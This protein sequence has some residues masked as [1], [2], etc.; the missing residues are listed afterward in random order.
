MR[1]ESEEED[2]T[3][4][5]QAAPDKK[6]VDAIKLVCWGGIALYVVWKLV[7]LQQGATF[8]ELF[9]FGDPSLWGLMFGACV[10]GLIL[11][12]PKIRRS[13][14]LIE[15]NETRAVTLS[16]VTVFTVMA[17]YYFLRPV[18][19]SMASDWSDTEISQLWTIQF[20]LSLGLVMIYGAACSKIR[21]R[22]LVPAVYTFYAVTFA[23]FFFGSSFVADRVLL[24]KSFYV[25]VSLFSLFHLSVFWSFMADTFSLEQSKRLF[26]FIGAGA[27]AGAAAAPLVVAVIAS[28]V[29]NDNL[30]LIAAVILLLAIPMVLYLQRLKVIDLHN[31]DVSANLMAAR[32]GGKWW[33]GFRDFVMNPYLLTIGV[34]ILL[35]TG[36]QGFIYFETTELLRIYEEREQRTTILALRDATVNILTFGFGLFV[37]GRLVTR[38]GMTATLALLPVFCA[39]G[40]VILAV[41]PILSVLLAVDIARR[42]GEYGITRPA[43]EMLFTSVDRETRFKTKPVVDVVVYRGGDAWWGGVFA[44]FSESVGLGFAAMSLIG[45]GLA[46]V[47]VACA[48]YLGRVFKRRERR[49]EAPEPAPIGDRAAAT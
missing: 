46:A 36:I 31:E 48:V 7:R 13:A 28:D 16:F 24:D 47:W 8:G 30:M 21:F 25:W 37:T 15:A 29:G 20:F 18:R 34:F 38:F 22:L 40:F 6:P 42:S 3:V 14:T 19:D 32:M 4:M 49:D 5:R 41:A 2:R 44:F 1:N 23:L 27:S 17:A 45:G 11:R 26:A 12:S 35:Y 43:R 33:T 39:I 9:D 10:V